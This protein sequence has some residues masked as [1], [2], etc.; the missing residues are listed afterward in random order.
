MLAYDSLLFVGDIRIS[1]VEYFKSVAW[2]ILLVQLLSIAYS[3]RFK[4]VLIKKIQYGL[5][6]TAFILILQ[7][8]SEYVFGE[9]SFLE[10]I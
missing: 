1:I 7:E 8:L 2:L 10:D 4:N 6:I 9:I 3:D 5:I